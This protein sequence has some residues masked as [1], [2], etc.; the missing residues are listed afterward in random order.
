MD[1]PEP[2]VGASDVL[3][4]IRAASV[5]GFD[6][7]EAN[8]YLIGMMEHRFPTVIGRDLAGVVEATGPEVTGFA[9]GDEVLGFVPSMPPLEKGSFAEKISGPDLVLVPKPAE[10]DFLEAAALP[11][12][13]SAALDLLEAVDVKEGDTVLIVGATGGVGSFAVQLAAR[14][15]AIV[16]ATARPDEEAFVR[17]LGATQTIDHSAGS[18]ADSVRRL[19]PD[20]VAVLIDLVNQR[21][22]LTDL[23]SVVASGG[24]VAT[25]LGAAD[26]EIFASRGVAAANVNAAP[27]A[28]KLRNL[29]NLASSG[30]LRVP[31]QAVYPL[32]QVEEAL[33]AFQQGT[34]GKIILSIAP[35]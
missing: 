28:D 14:R 23:G 27:T 24:R 19:Y 18:V 12:A 8:R 26:V 17:E 21:G 20:G 16:I 11:L 35:V 10:L 4:A 25:T 3:V 33:A 1:L 30:E 13:G 31:I 29:A 9:A 22:A 5:N 2:E 15:G 7:F 6:V 32:D 34:R